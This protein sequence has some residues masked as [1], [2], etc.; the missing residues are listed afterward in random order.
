M[1]R[2]LI[3]IFKM[4]EEIKKIIEENPLALATV[5]SDGSPHVIAVAFA[6]VEDDTIIVTD[7]YM[8]K[9]VEN[10]KK[11]PNI[12]LVVW[13][14]DMIGYKIQGTAK[15]FSEGKFVDFVKS[16]KENKNEH[17]KGAIVI[18]INNIDKC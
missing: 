1:R 8:K 16:L 11:S 6:K 4:E 15:Y 9:T 10:L 18:K 2:R 7:N 13:N 12:S 14:K 5:N 17:P 3:W